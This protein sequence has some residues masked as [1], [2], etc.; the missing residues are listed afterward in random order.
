MARKV[1][2]RTPLKKALAKKRAFSVKKTLARY[3]RNIVR[4]VGFD[5]HQTPYAEKLAVLRSI[6]AG[7]DAKKFD[8]LPLV[9]PR[10]QR[11]R[12]DRRRALQRVAKTYARVKPFVHRSFKAVTPKNKKNFDELKKYVGI[13]NF[14][15][16]RAIPVPA[17]HP[18]KTRVT[19]DKNHRVS[20]SEGSY[21]S[22]FFRFPRMPS[23]VDEAV[24]MLEAMLP[25][26]PAGH[27][28]IAS[29]HHFLIPTSAE[30]ELLVDELKSFYTVYGAKAPELVR[31]IFGFK[32][33]AGSADRAHKR[34]TELKTER[35]KAR[36]HRRE[37]RAGIHLKALKAM[38]LHFK[39]RHAAQVLGIPSPHEKGEPW[40]QKMS[41]EDARRIIRNEERRKANTTRARKTGR[42]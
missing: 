3:P 36:Q 29:R 11:A 21:K 17:T 37:A 7:F 8:T 23:G 35:G 41:E 27:Y 28:V 12:V 9:K 1:K 5:K 38:E 39:G 6:L 20:I 19:F 42:R 16:L 18:S 31:L 24:E 26:M 14:K 4:R 25:A 33:I 30:K 2:K 32:W 10:T 15:G 13:W 34:L 40:R 22:K